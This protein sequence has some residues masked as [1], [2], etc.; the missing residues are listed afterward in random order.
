VAQVTRL[1]R[2]EARRMLSIANLPELVPFKRQNKSPAR[3][4]A[5]P[6]AASG[7]RGWGA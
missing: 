3:S 5:L 1:T 7:V 6:G 2:D 4:G